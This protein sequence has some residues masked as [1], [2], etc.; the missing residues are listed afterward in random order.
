M[1]KY[2]VKKAIAWN[3]TGEVG[4]I[5]EMDDETAALYEPEYIEAI[6]APIPKEE[7]DES[8]KSKK[9]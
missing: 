2:R 6:E 3:G 4:T 9:K 8:K 7:E 5:V 1:S